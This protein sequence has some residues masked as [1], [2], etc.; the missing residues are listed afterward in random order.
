VSITDDIGGRTEDLKRIYQETGPELLAY[1]RRR[2]GSPELAE[3][4]LQE[5]FAAVMRHPRRLLQADC[6]R[7]YLFGVARNISAT[8]LRQAHPADA[9]LAD[10]VA[11]AET[12]DPR[13]DAMREAIGRLDPACARRWPTRKS[14]GFSTSPSARSGRASTMLSR[15]FARP[16]WPR[17]IYE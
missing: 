17:P 3:D 6:P 9:P 10:A 2:H 4:L 8:A 13:L 14:P 12:P 5:T 1:F 11:E 7:A 15:I 16:W